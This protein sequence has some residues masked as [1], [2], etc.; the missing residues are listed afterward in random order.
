MDRKEMQEL[1]RA[2]AS[3]NTMEGLAAYREFAQALTTPILQAIERD[4]I[5]RELFAV[6]RLG[7]GAQASYPVAEDF[8][9]PVWVLPGLGYVAQNFIEGIGEEVYVPTFTIDASGDWKLTYARDSRVDIAARAAEKAAKGLSDYEEECG[10]RVI[11]PA[12]TSNFFGKG[13]LGSRPAPIYEINP[14]STGA[15]YLSKELLNKMI[16]GFK[17]IG[18]T[19]TDLYVSPEDAADIREWTDTDIDPV[20]RR[21]IFQ[22][23]GMGS[24]WN[25][26]L[27]E[28]QHL[29]ATGL[30]NINGNSASYGKFIANVSEAYNNYTLDNPN[31]TAADGT[32]STLGETQVI[33]FDLS[34]NDSLVMPIRKDYE[35]HDDPTLLRVQKAGFFGWE[36]I[37]FACLDPRMLGIGVIDRSL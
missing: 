10:W 14:A 9:I 26:M 5:M 23:A 30:Y 36:E 31:V 27:H 21:E 13:L 22:A 35:A 32:V 25:V 11:I 6:E 17:R 19:L 12:A 16:V 28:I 2:T 29:G 24:I 34:V 18:R 8:E 4:S 37:G 3:I 1:F 7:P 15:G 33:G 20:T